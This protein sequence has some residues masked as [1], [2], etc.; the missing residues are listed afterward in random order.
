MTDAGAL[1]AGPTLNPCINAVVTVPPATGSV[2]EADD[3]L[4]YVLYSSAANPAGSI[5]ATSPTPSFTFNAAT[6]STGVTYYLAAMAG[7]NSGG[8]VDP[9]DPCLDFSNARQVIWR[10]LPSVE[11]T[12][13]AASVCPGGCTTLGVV[14]TGTPPFTVSYTIFS[15]TFTSPQFSTN[16]GSINACAPA[17]LPVGLTVTIQPSSVT[18]AYCVCQ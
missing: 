10:P 12:A 16:S 8:T 1:A 11:F 7:N 2:L 6:M 3:L 14:F 15:Q 17:W 4:Q 13:T 9:G 5:V 18:D